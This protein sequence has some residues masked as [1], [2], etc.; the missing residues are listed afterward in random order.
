M[1]EVK[2]S[3]FEESE[4]L[5]RCEPH[6]EWQ[7]RHSQQMIKDIC[8]YQRIRRGRPKWLRRHKNDPRM[9]VLEELKHWLVTE[10]CVRADETASLEPIIKRIAYIRGLTDPRE[11]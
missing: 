2:E 8:H 4:W 1:H 3:N 9:L 11:W 10:F 6:S 5:F 7:K